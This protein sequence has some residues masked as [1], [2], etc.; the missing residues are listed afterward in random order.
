M[1]YQA[2]LSALLLLFLAQSGLAADETTLRIIV[3]YKQNSTQTQLKERLNQRIPLP[4]TMMQ[5]LAGGA[6]LL[7]FEQTRPTKIDASIQTLERLRQDP[8]IEYAL[9]DRMGH[10]KPL[11][12][13][14][15]DDASIILSHETQWDEFSPPGG[16]MLESAAGRRD[17]AWAYTTGRAKNPVVVAVLDTGV[18]LNTSLINNLVRD[19]QGKIWG[20]NVAGNNTDVI[21]ETYTY[22]GT[23]VAG[24]IAAYGDVMLGIGENLKILPVKIPDSSG[25]FYESQ[26][27]NAIYW[28]AGGEVPGAPINTHP[29][30]VINMSFGV[31]ERPDRESEHCDKALQDALF[32][33]RSRGAV[34]TVA[35]GNDNLWEHYNAPGVCNSTI[36]VASTGPEGLRAYYSNYGPSVSFAAP[37][38]DLHYGLQGGILSTVNPGG[39]YFS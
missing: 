14:E 28:A 9:K 4:L 26:V 22:H 24:T 16:L 35:A 13:A 20:W 33:A 34:I 29:A 15:V 8:D 31:D 32:F 10:F 38:G 27:I 2:R 7:H 5:P 25:M 18:T 30:K 1:K 23:H 11:S 6:Y 17:G 36:K 19:E 3:K 37:G 12:K 21:D 39:G